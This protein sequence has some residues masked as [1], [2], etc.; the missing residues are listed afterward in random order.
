MKRL[1]LH[2]FI[3]IGFITGIYVNGFAQRGVGI[4]VSSPTEKLHVVGNFRLEGAFKPGN[5][6]GTNGQFLQSRG[7]GLAPIWVNAPGGGSFSGRVKHLARYTPNNNTLGVSIIQDD[8]IQVHVNMIP[9]SLP[10]ADM[11]NFMTV[12][13]P[14]S[15]GS[16]RRIAL[17]ASATDSAAVMGISN[18]LT[19]TSPNHLPPANPAGRLWGAV[20]GVVATTGSGA[21]VS[22][23]NTSSTAFG[24]GVFGASSATSVV[25]FG[26]QGAT[27]STQTN[28]LSGTLYASSAGISGHAM[29]ATGLAHGVQGWVSGNGLKSS[30]VYGLCTTDQQFGV[31]GENPAPN[32]IAVQGFATAIGDAEQGIGVQGRTDGGRDFS[33]GVRGIAANDNTI[34]APNQG[35]TYGVLGW[36]YSGQDSAAGVYGIAATT[37]GTPGK[38]S[39]GVIGRSYGVSDSSAGVLGENH[40]T[41]QLGIYGRSRLGTGVYGLHFAQTGTTAGVQGESRSRDNG[42]AGIRGLASGT[43]GTVYGVWGQIASSGTNSAG[44][45]GDTLT[46]ASYGSTWAVWGQGSIRATG[47]IV[48]GAKLFQ[49]DHPLDPEN[50]YLQHICP[51]SNEPLN[52]YAGIVM[53]DRYGKATVTLPEYVGVINK[54]FRYQFTCMNVFAQAIVSKEFVN[55]SFEVQTNQPNVKVSWV[56]YGVRN[57]NYMK[58]YPF[59]AEKNKEPENKGLYLHPQAFG[60]PLEKSIG[61]IPQADYMKEILGKRPIIR[62]V[63]SMSLEQYAKEQDEHLKRM[64]SK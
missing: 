23:Y 44:V 24:R 57:D 28:P 59:Q 26:V 61:Y 47:N 16:N 7:A 12:T 35:K 62:S 6:A 2:V 9:G 45:R 49:T 30:G 48:G 8:S 33:V 19:G 36:T 55:N 54:D 37:S 52:I 34:T 29:G 4:G 56:L 31:L 27:Y 21:G 3:L 64:R 53:T 63:P 20:S 46:G 60:Q 11:N 38:C 17:R 5:N 10:T 22:G 14:G 1:L 41:R 51:E 40:G 15:G 18:S 50:K 42:A 39:F 25:T 58:T 32:G 43:S 13:A